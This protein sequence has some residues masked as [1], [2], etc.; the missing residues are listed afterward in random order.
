MPRNRVVQLLSG[1][2]LVAGIILPLMTP[3]HAARASNTFS[4]VCD[5][6]TRVPILCL[7]DYKGKRAGGNPILMEGKSTEGRAE[8]NAQVVLPDTINEAPDPASKKCGG[9]VS[10]RCPFASTSWDRHYKGD[11]LLTLA[12]PAVG[13][14]NVETGH[15]LGADAHSDKAG[16]AICDRPDALFVAAPVHSG[17]YCA[18]VSVYEMNKHRGTKDAYVLTGTRK[19][20]R[21]PSR[22]DEVTIKE[23]SNAQTQYWWRPDIGTECGLM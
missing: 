12:F 15:C 20:G 16:L 11:L 23:W 14:G 7:T 13:S 1:A 18:L 9:K 6:P 10:S 17:R 2:T 5:A 8:P 22:S 4:W 19:G 21:T 3:P